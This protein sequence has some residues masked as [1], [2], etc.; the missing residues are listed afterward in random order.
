MTL[1]SQAIV[2]LVIAVILV[3]LVLFLMSGSNTTN[4]SIDESQDA[5]IASI[6]QQQQMLNQRLQVLENRPS[7][8]APIRTVVQQG[9]MDVI[10]FT[11]LGVEENSDPVTVNYSFVEYNDGTYL[12]YALE[13]DAFTIGPVFQNSAGNNTVRLTNPSPAFGTVFDERFESR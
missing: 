11:A 8:G 13:F 4:R 7:T 3:I 1:G 9:T 2:V 6:Q 5:A 10:F 12:R